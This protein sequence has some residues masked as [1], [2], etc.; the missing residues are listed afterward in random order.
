MLEE[1]RILNQVVFSGNPSFV[2][3]KQY[4]LCQ[5]TLLL[6]VFEIITELK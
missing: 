3:Y 1:Q 5:V 2:I 4:D 6:L